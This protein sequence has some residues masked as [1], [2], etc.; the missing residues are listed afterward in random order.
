MVLAI[1][2]AAVLLALA[3]SL[4]ASSA[5]A[6]KFH[7]YTC[8]TPNGESAPADGWSASK[9][10][11]YT[12]AADT[13]QQPGGALVAALRDETMRTPNT[14]AARWAFVASP[15][16]RI[17]GATLW[18]A[19]DA[20]GGAEIS[21][22]YQ[23]WLGAPTE[24]II[25]D[26]CPTEGGCTKLGDPTQPLTAEN[27]VVVPSADLNSRLD[28]NASC[29]GLPEYK[30]P[31]GQHDSNGY[32]AVIY[33]YAADL[34]LEQTAGPSAG[35][36]SGELASA[37]TVSGARD[38]AFSASDPGAGVYEVVFSVDGQAIQSTVV[39][40]NGGRCKNVG[41]TSDGLPAF[42]YMQPCLASVNADVGFDTTKVSNGVHHLV[43]SVVDAAGNAAPVLDRN[44]TIDNPGAAGSPGPANGTNA[45]AQA[46]LTASWKGT[47]R[48]RIRSL[49]GREETIDGRLSAPGGMA[50][51]GAQ[52]EMH[53]TPAYTGA[54]TATLA[55]LVTG[56][57]GRFSIRVPR[58]AS[59]RTLRL[60]YRSHIGDA[61]PA[62]TRT[63]TLSVE[64]GIGLS[65][66]PRTASV[67]RSIFFRGRLLGGPVP[68]G[69]KQLVLE[70]RSPGGPWI[71]FDVVRTDSRGRYRSSYRFKFPG[72]ASYQF[73][74]RS[75]A[76]ADY[77]FAGGSSKVLDVFEQ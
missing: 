11:L 4:V 21:A 30:C 60:A 56:P 49:F 16:D 1:L 2:K 14:E 27:R 64:A 44:L 46:M 15:E 62:A 22:W 77:P 3:L 63:L 24:S 59:S 45:S 19:G 25:F 48:D 71:E 41:Q 53:A 10:G 13:C 61:L 70:A 40:E 31:A 43:V 17:T 57:D 28:A 52:I 36:V 9:T 6:G 37:Q 20:Y 68:K 38:V 29:S 33:L 76:E 35:N 23:F 66:T 12:Y 55:S 26:P 74:V 69:G 7:L 75:E 67:G 34:V 58:G 51:A 47:R 8:R 5:Q 42:L 50:I 32:S 73:R 39:D 54:K 72:P 18:R 65:I